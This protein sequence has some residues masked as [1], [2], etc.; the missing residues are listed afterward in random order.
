MLRH[1]EDIFISVRLNETCYKPKKID[2]YTY[3][4]QR[5]HIV[6]NNVF[7]INETIFLW[8]RYIFHS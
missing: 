5:K 1:S 3:S 2:M 4:Y 7:R 6:K 8:E